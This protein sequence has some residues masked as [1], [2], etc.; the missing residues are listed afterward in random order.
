[1]VASKRED[2]GEEESDVKGVMLLVSQDLRLLRQDVRGV[3]EVLT[4]GLFTMSANL[5]EL[6][7]NLIANANNVITAIKK[8]GKVRAPWLLVEA[9]PLNSR[10]FTRGILKLE[11]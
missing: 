10:Q 3:R 11:E 6:T 1:M 4:K 9:I 2:N 8:K 5:K 7:N